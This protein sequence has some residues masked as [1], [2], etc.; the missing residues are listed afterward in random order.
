MF[1]NIVRRIQNHPLIFTLTHLRGNPRACTYTEPLWGIPHA[2]YSPYM[3]VYMYA[4]GLDDIAIGTVISIGLAF[5]VFS[6][7][8]GGLITDRIG[9]RLTTFIFDI[10]SWSV[11]VLIWAF[12]NSMWM[13]VAAAIGNGFWQI[14]N[15]SWTC[16]LVE[17]AEQD[18]LVNIY[19]WI[20]IAG[21]LSVFFAP[22]AGQLIR[23]YGLIPAMRAIL[24]FTF[25]SMTAKFLL[26]FAFTTETR[27]GQRRRDELRH[28]SLKTQLLQYRPVIRAMLRQK[29]VVFIFLLMVLVQISSTITLNFFALY[30][31]EDLGIGEAFLSYFPLIRAGIMF[32]LIFG[33]QTRLN[34]LPFRIPLG[35]GL[36][37]YALAQ[38]LLLVAPNGRLPMLFVYTAVEAF[39]FSLV[40]PQRDALL[41]IFL[42]ENERARQLS[43]IDAAVVALSAPFG[44]LAG[45]LSDQDRRLP[46]VLNILCYLICLLLV[47][48]ARGLHTQEE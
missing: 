39:A 16:L 10:L 17:D 12:S 9:R 41:T 40:I 32:L 5:Q 38:V 21:L 6:A 22:I 18:Q 20:T 45:W 27:A 28:I 8:L 46:F 24:I 15:N 23:H 19:T 26:L 33:I 7:L 3:T 35:F 37:L 36:G 2:L 44:M 25:V 14:T 31:T 30:V 34:R 4:L 42:D 29:Q 11:P 1:Q 43:L 47:L 48:S 13:F